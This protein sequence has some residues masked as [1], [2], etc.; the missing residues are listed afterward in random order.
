MINLTEQ[1]KEML[2]HSGFPK[3]QHF[4]FGPYYAKLVNEERAIKELIGYEVAQKM[5]VLC[6][7]GKIVLLDGS[8]YFLSEDL[9][10]YGKFMTAEDLEIGDLI[11]EDCS[12]YEIW[13]FLETKYGTAKEE[14][15]DLIKIYIFDVLFFHFDRKKSNWGILFLKDGKR[16]VVMLDNEFL[17]IENKRDVMQ[18]YVGFEK[19]QTV[20]DDFK[21]FLEESSEEFISLFDYY[22]NLFTP[23]YLEKLVSKIINDNHLIVDINSNDSLLSFYSQLYNLENFEQLKEEI[24]ENNTFVEEAKDEILNFYTSNHQTLGD[25]YE[26][27]RKEKRVK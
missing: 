6:P 10:Q 25:I 11:D 17:L 22:Y 9:N 3:C 2:R 27:L 15:L 14:M 20:Y 7:Q 23:D 12:L 21:K 16:K 5:G 4:S 1:D 19:P 8:Y 26:E 24:A 13:N 18:T